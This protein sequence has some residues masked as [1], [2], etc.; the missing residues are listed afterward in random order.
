MLIPLL[1]LYSLLSSRPNLPILV[2]SARVCAWNHGKC[3]LGYGD[4]EEIEDVMLKLTIISSLVLLV[5]LGRS[6]EIRKAPRR[7]I[8][9]PNEKGRA[10]KPRRSVE[11]LN[12]G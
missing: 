11:V 8:S 3:N 10:R 1:T 9:Q 2:F 4:Q 5:A 7:Y 12:G 6:M